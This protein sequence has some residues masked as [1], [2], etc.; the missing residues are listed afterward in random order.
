MRHR[1]GRDRSPLSRLFHEHAR[2]QVDVVAGD[3]S[4]FTATTA[5]VGQ[6]GEE[7]VGAAIAL[8]RGQQGVDVRTRRRRPGLLG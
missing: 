4:Q 2:L 8:R 3:G 1:Q 6:H 5:G 7:G